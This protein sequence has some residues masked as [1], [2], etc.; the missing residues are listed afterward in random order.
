MKSCSHI[1]L[2]AF[3][4]SDW[5]EVLM[6]Y[7]R[8]RW[9]DKSQRVS[10]YFYQAATSLTAVRASHSLSEGVTLVYETAS[11]WFSASLLLSTAAQKNLSQQNEVKPV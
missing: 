7:P 6:V 8:G 2:L 9:G 1:F 10:W 11:S 4:K 5:D 3:S